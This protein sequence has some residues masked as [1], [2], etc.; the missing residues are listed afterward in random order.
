MDQLTRVV[1][2]KVWFLTQRTNA[3]PLVLALHALSIWALMERQPCV[4]LSEP[5]P[6]HSQK[7][8]G[9]RL[10]CLAYAFVQRGLKNEPPQPPRRTSTPTRCRKENPGIRSVSAE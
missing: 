2:S 10:V 1:N 9:V 7:S 8:N 5:D 4:S 3:H 6:N